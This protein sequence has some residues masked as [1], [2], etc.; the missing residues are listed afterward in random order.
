MP[1]S[2]AV[3]YMDDGCFSDN[4]CIIATDGFSQDD[5]CFLQKLLLE[6]F[7]IKTSVK[8]KSKLL[9]KKESIQIFFSIIRPHIIPS[10]LYKIFDPVT[11]SPGGEMLIQI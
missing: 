7:N 2:L 9:I 11:T 4:K 8:N 1:L 3:W 10:M 6:K 5:I